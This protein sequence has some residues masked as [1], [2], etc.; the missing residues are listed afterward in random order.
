MKYYFHLVS[1]SLRIPDDVGV[2]A[3][4]MDEA[5]FSALKAAQELHSEVDAIE[6]PPGWLEMT[7]AGDRVLCKIKLAPPRP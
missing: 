2:E 3:G 7:D 5:F 4:S 1:D 6:G